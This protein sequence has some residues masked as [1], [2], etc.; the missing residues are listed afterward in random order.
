MIQKIFELVKN[1]F[2][3]NLPPDTD[4]DIVHKTVLNNMV[5]IVTGIF[6]ALLSISAHYNNRPAIVKIDIAT[7]L[8]MAVSFLVLRITRRW[9]IMS[10]F[11]VLYMGTLF[12]LLYY[13]G[14]V[15]STGMYWSF[16]FPPLALFLLGVFHGTI[17]VVLYTGMTV[18]AFLFFPS[19]FLQSDIVLRSI[20]RYLAA[21]SALFSVSA[22][23]EWVRARTHVLINR[24]NH[25]LEKALSS[26]K[27][28]EQELQKSE[29]RWRDVTLASSHIIW[30]TDDAFKYTYVN[31]GVIEVLGYHPH[32]L[33][34]SPFSLLMTPQETSRVSTVLQ[35]RCFSGE[36]VREF[37]RILLHKQGR[38]IYIVSTILP[39][40]DNTGRVIGLR[41]V[42]NDI[43]GKKEA[44]QERFI[45]ENKMRVL[46]KLEA[47]GQLAGGIAH[48][49]NNI[50]GA[51]SGY[52][53]MIKQ[54]FAADKPRLGKYADTILAASQ[55][56]AGLTEKLLA[57][58]RRGTHQMVEVDIHLLI[59]EFISMLKPLV[60]DTISI[61]V[62]LSANNPAVMG[63]PSQ[64]H[65]ILMNLAL[66]ARDA[67]PRGGKLM[68]DTTN[69]HLDDTFI[70]R[71]HY[72]IT[73][74]EYLLIGVS[75]SGTGMTSEIKNRI[76]EPFFTT[77]EMGKG[78]GMGL[79]SVYGTV[80]SH[81]GYV[82]VYTETGVGTTFKIYFPC[83]D[84]QTPSTSS[85][86][87]K[88]IVPSVT[89]DRKKT[90]MVVDDE[91]FML[92]LSTEMLEILGCTSVPFISS[93]EALPYYRQNFATIDAVIL[94]MIMPAGLSGEELL[95]EL[96]SINPS[97]KALLSTGY[98]LART[99]CDYVAAGFS[100]LIQK[101]FVVNQ[102]K[103]ALEEVLGIDL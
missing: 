61:S 62:T 101:P 34:G 26:L 4:R 83:I 57:F 94:D 38:R 48:D 24:S 3:S 42:D 8:I 92:T 1:I 6:T 17:A 65:N 2:K 30:E 49:F 76:F 19:S 46:Q 80:K 13:T 44:E 10:Y 9:R 32:E 90:I 100:G 5:F 43:T 40:V 75:D 28:R 88:D 27:E 20:S 102:L 12:F 58:A 50:I 55:R 33:I 45:L 95:M 71:H 64:L 74:G 81:H 79:A 60:G 99:E 98:G 41:G 51:I 7:T 25:E 37:N 70:R 39:I 54:R 97:V 91:S 53:D 21:F 56:A 23:Y 29:K 85:A 63:D 31:E 73:P 93:E 72:E 16:C 22:L 11:S 59:E 47:V 69:V 36:T 14:G 82:N 35:R 103:S 86:G 18:G 52:A 96:K 89:P 15:L 77:K 67:M 66:N 84:M 87:E 78:T 68:F